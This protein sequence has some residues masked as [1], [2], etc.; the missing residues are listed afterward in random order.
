MVELIAAAHVPRER[1][2]PPPGGDHWG[3]AAAAASLP[4]ARDRSCGG[5]AETDGLLE[6][7]AR[8]DACAFRWSAPPCNRQR[9]SRSA[10]NH[11]ALAAATG[12]PADQDQRTCHVAAAGPGTRIAVVLQSAS[13]AQGGGGLT[14]QALQ[15]PPAVRDHGRRA[16]L[17]LGAVV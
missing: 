3:P 14:Q 5:R 4:A 12:R 15:E 7:A 11:L 6:I 17:A 16:A 8:A 9:R 1:T 10:E 13:R 2:D